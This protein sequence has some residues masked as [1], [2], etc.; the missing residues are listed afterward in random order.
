[1]D[2]Q[3]SVPGAKAV[4]DAHRD[5]EALIGCGASILLLVLKL[6]LGEDVIVR[7][8]KMGVGKKID[9]VV[10]ACHRDALCTCILIR[11]HAF[12]GLCHARLAP[13]CL[14]MTE[15]F[16]IFASEALLGPE[17]AVRCLKVLSVIKKTSDW[18]GNC[19]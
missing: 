6:S 18:P 11:V 4:G 16:I 15:N 14:L 17:K 2:L 13:S 1:M 19:S 10:A 5:G 12:P 9:G 3:T 7:A 8:T